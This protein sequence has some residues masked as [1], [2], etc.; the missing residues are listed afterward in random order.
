MELR[1]IDGLDQDGNRITIKLPIPSVIQQVL[2]NLDY[3]NGAISTLDAQ[4]QL[5][6]QFCLSDEQKSVL[7]SDRRG[8][9]FWRDEVNGEINA[10]VTEKML[11][12]IKC[13]KK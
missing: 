8:V 11:I 3:S 6:G 4:D 7:R 13:I 2:L 5:A 9:N 12:F 1:E 10:L